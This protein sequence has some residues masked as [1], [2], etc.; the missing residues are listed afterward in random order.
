[1][2][3]RRHKKDNYTCIDNHVF[4]DD[5]LSMKAKGLLAQIYSLPDDWEYSVKGLTLLFSDGKDAVNNALQEL[6]DH[7]YIIRTQR[8]NKSGKFDGYEYDIYETPQTEKA[9]KPITE[10]PSTDNPITDN[11]PQL[12]TNILNTKVSNTKV[13]NIDKESKPK[14]EPSRFIPP[15]V[16]EVSAYCIERGNSVNPQRFIDHYTS[17]GWM[18]GKNKMKDWQAAVRTWERNALDQ[19]PAP[20]VQKKFVNPFE[21]LEKEL[22]YDTEG[23]D[24]ALEAIIS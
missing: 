11:L 14:K 5:S 22:G 21:E 24:P 8:I 1:M 4:R 6:I 7:G 9:E 12:N 17:N 18:V 23:I 15:T 13:L 19:K 16:E 10:N 3:Y 20:Q 2:K